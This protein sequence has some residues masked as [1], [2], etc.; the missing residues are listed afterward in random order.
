[1]SET[2]VADFRSLSETQ[3][4]GL[5]LRAGRFEDAETCGSICY[6]AF[7]AIADQHNFPPIFHRRRLRSD[8]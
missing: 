6:G 4:A 8:W 1:M 3:A 7:K 5:R 2:H